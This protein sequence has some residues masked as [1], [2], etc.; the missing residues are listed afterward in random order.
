MIPLFTYDDL[1][2]TTKIARRIIVVEP[3]KTT[4]TTN[5]VS[6]IFTSFGVRATPDRYSES[7]AKI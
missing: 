5:P 7:E 3:N 6:S 4:P 2:F 1:H